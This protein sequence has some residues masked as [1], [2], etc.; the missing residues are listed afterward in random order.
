M[1][2]DGRLA[3]GTSGADVF[4]G[5]GSFEHGKMAQERR[6][7]VGGREIVYMLGL[8]AGFSQE[9][10]DEW[11]GE[12]RIGVQRLYDPGQVWLGTALS[13]FGIVYNRDTLRKIGVQEPRSFRDLC[14]PRYFNMLALADGR[15]EAVLDEWAERFPGPFLYFVGRRHLPPPLRAFVDFL[16][17]EP[18]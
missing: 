7:T 1:G 8:P 10:L 9:Q 16:R 14:D 11:Y 2:R 3:A 6:A 4:F 17:S 12:N 5:G 13:G 15:L 18:G